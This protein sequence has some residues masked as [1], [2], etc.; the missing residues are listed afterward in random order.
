[1][2]AVLLAVS[3]AAAEQGVARDT[4]EA[5]SL[6]GATDDVACITA[7]GLTRGT[8]SGGFGA[9][10]PVTRG[11]MATFLV[12]L[13][14]AA[15]I[16]LPAPA[17]DHFADDD[18]DAHERSIDQL[19][20]AGVSAG[21]GDG[22]FG[23]A[24]PVTRDQMA[25][26]VGNA[27]ERPLPGVLPSVTPD[28]FDDDDSSV[29]EDRIEQL[30]ELG[31]VQGVAFGRY[32]PARP[33]TR[34]QM[35]AFLSRSLDLLAETDGAGV[36]RVGVLGATAAPELVATTASGGGTVVFQFD[37]P[38]RAEVVASAFTVWSFAAER[39]AATE[40][41][42]D[43]AAP[44]RVIA[45]FPTEAVRLATTGSVT[46]GAVVGATG[47]S[48]AEGAAGLRRLVLAPGT[49]SAP[50]LIGVGRLGGFTVDFSFDEP[51]LVEKP[52]GYHLILDDG[53]VETSTS[54]LG[55]GDRTHVVTFP[56]LT[57][58]EADRVVRAYVDSATV[59]DAS[60][61]GGG[62]LA[63]QQA[64]DVAGAGSLLGRPDLDSIEADSATGTVRFLF[65]EAVVVQSGAVFRGYSLDGNEV[66]AS[67]PRSA[68]DPTVV[69]VDFPGVELQGASVDGGAVRNPSTGATNLVDEIGISRT[70]EPGRT[71]GPDLLA[72]LRT[73]LGS[74]RTV[75]FRFDQP[76]EFI[77]DDAFSI[78]D[79]A[80][81]RTVLNGCAAEANGTS[82][83]CAVDSATSPAL[84]ARVGSARRAGVLEAAVTDGAGTHVNPPS[85]R[86][87]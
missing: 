25:T 70:F 28:Y 67:S 43:P 81:A 2:V 55:G 31:V 50:D 32:E 58:A 30:A 75:I 68:A 29:H 7:F 77:S 41:Q 59:R 5:C 53:S 34:R 71:A 47:L 14:A 16:E 11:Q 52:D 8:A 19:V 56:G 4:D 9:G 84:H 15:G 48:S 79:E 78:Y 18:G 62:P 80:G 86:A 27:L 74:V 54:A 39:T 38:V 20:E 87:L 33:I 23:P 45:T 44:T 40:A 63:P 57:A 13:L 73:Q 69:V 10:E 37:A 72:V 51:A 61:Q 60:G 49:T 83:R 3:P 24:R 6:V 85:G 64:V 21:F 26:F 22:T 65:D 42:R 66:I 1:M 36:S 12:R 76:V 35:A 46:T 17:L 82:V